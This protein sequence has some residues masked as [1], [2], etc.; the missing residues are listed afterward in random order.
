MSITIELDSDQTDEIIRTEMRF[1]IECFER[2]LEERRQGKG[3]GIFDSDP[4]QDVMYII[5]QI[6]AFE[7]VLDWCGGDVFPE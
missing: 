5:K 7:L 1:M 2:D 4:E 6:E 3:I